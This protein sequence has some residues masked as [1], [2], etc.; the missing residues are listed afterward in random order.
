MRIVSLVPSWTEYVVDLGLASGLVGRT[1]F[2]VRAGNQA[3]GIPIIGGTKRIHLERIEKLKPDIVIASKEENTR[4]DVEACRAFAD[5]LVTDVRS[6]ESAFDAL[7]CIGEVLEKRAAANTW[8]S[9][10]EKAWGEPRPLNGEALYAIWQN[11]FMVAGRDTFINAVMNWWGIGNA[12][13]EGTVG[14]Y[15]E[16]S[17]RQLHGMIGIPVMLSSEPYPFNRKH[18]S[19]FASIGLRPILVDGESF[20]WYGSRMLHAKEYLSSMRQA[21]D[22]LSH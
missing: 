1:K 5:V 18:C 15:P 16:L 20:S 13:P 6:V 17:E 22:D 8:R 19:H 11:P 4:E 9:E 2:C 7:D 3:E 14:R 10:I 21:L 12:L